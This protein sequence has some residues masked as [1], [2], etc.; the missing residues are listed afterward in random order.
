MESRGILWRFGNSECL[1]ERL[2]AIL[3]AVGV[4]VTDQEIFDIENQR[5]ESLRSH[6]LLEFDSGALEMLLTSLG[7]SPVFTSYYAVE[8]VCDLIELYYS[9]RSA[10]SPDIGDLELVKEIAASFEASEGVVELIELDAL[11]SS[12]RDPW[13][14]SR[15]ALD[16]QG[17]CHQDSSI[18]E[19]DEFS[20]GWD[21]EEWGVADDGE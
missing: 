4:S 17:L 7:Q 16:R 13:E 8:T 3:G 6:G 18:W 19:Y 20:I 2:A 12:F 1:G 11:I 10:C 21:G 15:E 5:G 9:L 14:V